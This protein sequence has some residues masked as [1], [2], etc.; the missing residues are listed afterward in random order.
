MAFGTI[1]AIALHDCRRPLEPSMTETLPQS[2]TAAAIATS[3]ASEV[4][5][6]VVV[7]GGGPAGATMAAL[8]ARDGFAV[9]LL[10]R[11][12]H[13]RFHIGESLLPANVQLFEQLGVR[14]QVEAIGMPKWGV[15]FVS[16]QHSHTAFVEFSEAWD[17]T[18]PMAWQVRRSALDDMLFRNAR[19][20]GAATV[21]G[22]N[23]RRVEFDEAGAT[24][25]A[26]LDDGA[27][28]RWRT[29]HVVDASGRDT[30]LA[31]Q[32]QTKARNPKHNSAAIFGHFR[33]ARRLEG[34][35]LE[36]N[37]SIFWFE[38]GWIWFIPL[39][40]GTTSV[41]A[42][43]WPAYLKTRDKPLKAFFLDTLAQAPML[44]ER[45]ADA[46]LVDDEVHATGNYSYSAAQASGARWLMLG[47]AFAFV[48]PVFS[49]GVY[50][51]MESAFRALP[52]VKATLR[53]P[54]QAAAERR[55]FEAHMRKGPREFS[56]FIYRMT[57]PAMREL[58]MHPRNILRAKEA[59][60]SVLA[61][62]IFSATPYRPSLAFFKCVYW[63]SSLGN[64]PRS[65]RAWRRRR[66]LI[67]DRGPLNGETVM[68]PAQ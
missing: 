56:W 51:A 61:G 16:P 55:R 14:A 63:V 1:G 66:R 18:M 37:I 29:A 17:K 44:M 24:V 27:E 39:L 45:L 20:Q 58:F 57:N 67:A 49:S 28:R 11:E 46:T 15:Q 53:Q 19:S 30:L 3:T 21:E 36:G 68:K 48:D 10:E 41:G 43:C 40:D 8:L 62:D 25:H 35:K 50:L 42:T 65:W 64:L 4:I 54:Q 52:V 7:I 2:T 13:P 9:S 33:N 38:H 59:V 22:C 47:D 34:E 12:H 26:L 5:C 23:V 6:D 60:M 32:F 31:S